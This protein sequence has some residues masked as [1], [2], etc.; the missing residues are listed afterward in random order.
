MRPLGQISFI[1]FG[2]PK[3]DNIKSGNS[4]HYFD[5]LEDFYWSSFSS[6]MVVGQPNNIGDIYGF[7]DSVDYPL[8][9]GVSLYTIFDTGTNDILISETYFMNVVHT[10]FEKVGGKDWTFTGG[11]LYS[12]CYNNFPSI[13]FDVS[14]KLVELRPQDYVVDISRG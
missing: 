8:K 14:G 5:V 11:I 12:R 13:F 10:I 9:D 2:P 4:I 6:G 1:N 7:E 3:L